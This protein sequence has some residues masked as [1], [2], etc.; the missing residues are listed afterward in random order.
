[1]NRARGSSVGDDSAPLPSADGPPRVAAPPVS[2]K[3]GVGAGRRIERRR[4]ACFHSRALPKGGGL[5]SRGSGRVVRQCGGSFSKGGRGRWTAFENGAGRTVEAERRGARHMPQWRPVARRS[6]GVEQGLLELGNRAG[7][8]LPKLGDGLVDLVRE[9]V[10]SFINAP[11][12]GPLDSFLGD[13]GDSKLVALGIGQAHKAFM[14]GYFL[15]DG[16]GRCFGF[17][18][19][20][21]LSLTWDVGA[22]SLSWAPGL[23]PTVDR[24]GSLGAA[25]FSSNSCAPV[26]AAAGLD[27]GPS[28]CDAGGGPLVWATSLEAPFDF[29]ST[30]VSSLVGAVDVGLGSGFAEAGRDGRVPAVAFA[31]GEPTAD[32]TSVPAT[33]CS[34]RLAIKDASSVLDIAV[35]RKARLQDCGSSRARVRSRPSRKMIIGLSRRC[36]VALGEGEADSLTEFVSHGL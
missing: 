8:F 28:G 33:R 16:C 5:T 18:N 3:T 30:Q 24:A 17:S 13:G 10:G 1:M 26:D 23:S 2:M 27:A 35:A 31:H 4:P 7:V 22:L 32:S 9:K 21:G 29:L 25:R 36:G 20:W 14:W 34:P 6:T 19:W 11:F 12:N 15:M